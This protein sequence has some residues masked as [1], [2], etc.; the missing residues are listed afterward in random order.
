MLKSVRH[1]WHGSMRAREIGALFALFA[2]AALVLLFGFIASEVAEGDTKPLD[3]AV[4]LAF[5]TPGNS[6]DLLGPPWFEEMIRDVTALGSYTF[7]LILIAATVGYLLILQKYRLAAV[8]SAAELGGMLI[9]NL[10]KTAFARPRPEI[11]H[12]ARVFTPSFPSGHATLSAVTFLTLGA[13]LTRTSPNPR[14]KLYFMGLAIVLTVI[15]GSSRVYL[16]VHYPSDVLAGWC[17]GSAWAALCWGV[18]LWL[19]R[20]AP[21]TRANR[22]TDTTMQRSD[23]RHI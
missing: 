13:L 12:A 20:T 18:A 7:I 9:S 19:Q 14:V 3:E 5:R 1:S 22:E 11:E 8:V 23:I 16:G 10:L 4:L 17:I 21:V 2:S 6:G 15:V